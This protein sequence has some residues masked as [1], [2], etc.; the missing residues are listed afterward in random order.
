MAEVSSRLGPGERAGLLATVM[1][2]AED[3]E[4][5][6]ALGIEELVGVA[7]LVADKLFTGQ[8]PPEAGHTAKRESAAALPKARRVLNLIR[9]LA[10]S[11]RRSDDQ[12]VL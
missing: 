8:S 1:A 10:L 4:Q 7:R 3:Q 6:G 9:F 2:A 5:F 11:K 12:L